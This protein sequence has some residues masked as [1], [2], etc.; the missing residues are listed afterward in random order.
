MYRLVAIALLFFVSY[1]GAQKQSKSIKSAKTEKTAT[2]KKINETQKKLSDNQKQ[3]QQSLRELNLLKGEIDQKESQ[4][5]RT[6]LQVDSINAEIKVAEDSITALNAQ[7]DRLKETYKKALRKLQSSRSFTDELSYIFSSRSF[8]EA[9]ARMRYVRDFGKWRKRKVQEISRSAQNIEQKRQQLSEL[10]SKRKSSLDLLSNDQAMLKAKQD[11]TDRLVVRLQADGRSLQSSL[12]AEKKRLQT[13]NSEIN[14]MIEQERREAERKE[15][16]RKE[17]ERRAREEQKRKDAEKRRKGQT[18]E[19]PKKDSPADKPGTPAS[20][21][22]SQPSKPTQPK[23]SIDNSDPDAVLTRRF[24]SARGS[25][26]FPVASPYR[27]V[28]KYGSVAGQPYNTG[29]EILLD[30]ANA[31]RAVFDGTVSRIFQNHDGNYTVM[32]R[33]G[34]YIA[35]YYNIASP[36]VKAGAVVK[37][38]TTIGSVGHDASYGK[39]MLHFEIR[40]G[41]QTLNPL[42]WVK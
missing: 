11:E 40:K 8:K 34:A 18:A 32:V 22:P 29:I 4:I 9:Y 33:H 42:S 2:Q 5:A 10:H 21:N 26:T 39:P 30:G 36:S 14:R 1:A 35:V 6:R 19:T 25:M 3:T 27:I 12:E 23:A 38:G 16:E 28:G 31:A 15:K 7:L 37:S 24:E 13:I 20:P 17:R 41:S